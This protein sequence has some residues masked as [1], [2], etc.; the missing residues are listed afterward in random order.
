MFRICKTPIRV[1]G[2]LFLLDFFYFNLVPLLLSLVW[3][4]NN[5]LACWSSPAACVG[6]RFQRYTPPGTCC[7]R[8]PSSSALN[9]EVIR[10]IQLCLRDS[11]SAPPSEAAPAPPAPAPLGDDAPTSTSSKPPAPSPVLLLDGLDVPPRCSVTVAGRWRGLL[12][13]LALPRTL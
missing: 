6:S 3:R 8:L 2:A 1:H 13:L 9:M 10:V 11:P 7:M 5:S 4:P 12:V